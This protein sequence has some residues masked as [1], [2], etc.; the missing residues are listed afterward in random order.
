MKRKRVLHICLIV[1]W[2][3]SLL[4][5]GKLAFQEPPVEPETIEIERPLIV[6]KVVRDIVEKEVIVE[7]VVTLPP[8]VVE[9]V[10]EVPTKLR[11]FESSQD[12]NAWLE[13]RAYYIP[14]YPG[15]D[16]D[17][18]TQW[19]IEEAEKDGYRLSTELDWYHGNYHMY[20][21]A[22]IGNYIYLI[23]AQTHKIIKEFELD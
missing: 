23:D 3:L 15:C 9:V 12:L 19:R 1:L 6:T 13:T 17:D 11:G 20:A 21:S 14:S 5:L 10:Q 7:R 18:F 16:C 8:E 4:V 2:L 22:I